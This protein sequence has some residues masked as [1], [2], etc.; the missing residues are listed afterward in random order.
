MDPGSFFLFVAQLGYPGLKA[1]EETVLTYWQYI[2][3]NGLVND[4]RYSQYMLTHT[5]VFVP[6]ATVLVA[7][8]LLIPCGTRKVSLANVQV[9]SGLLG[10]ASHT[11][12]T[13][14]GF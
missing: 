2:Y 6:S 13:S 1:G 10:R 7:I 14:Q 8:G 12:P 4:S 9:V 3:Q 11:A 5:F